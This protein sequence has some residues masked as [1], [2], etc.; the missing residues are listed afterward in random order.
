METIQEMTNSQET[1]HKPQEIIADNTSIEEIKPNQTIEEK[2]A[3]AIFNEGVA[4]NGLEYIQKQ[5]QQLHQDKE[6]QQKRIDKWKSFVKSNTIEE[7]N[8]LDV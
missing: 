6:E 7:Y 4:E 1:P 5:R 8:G 2:E 3:V